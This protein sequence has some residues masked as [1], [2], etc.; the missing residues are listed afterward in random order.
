M[1]LRSAHVLDNLD[2]YTRDRSLWDRRGLV[3]D[4]HECLALGY[5]CPKMDDDCRSDFR[6]AT[7]DGKTAQRSM[8]TKVSTDSKTYWQRDPGF[9]TFV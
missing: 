9:L 6:A 5:G 7:S 3:I 1:P 2:A 4:L 8:Y